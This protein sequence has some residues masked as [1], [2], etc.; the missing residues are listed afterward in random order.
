MNREKAVGKTDT[1][2][3]TLPSR[4]RGPSAGQS[5]T[6]RSFMTGLYENSN[7]VSSEGIRILRYDY[8]A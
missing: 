4:S 1:I 2:E 8:E 7:H 3:S 6:S 5:C